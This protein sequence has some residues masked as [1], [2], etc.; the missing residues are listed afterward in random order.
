MGGRAGKCCDRL[1]PMGR[2][3]ELNGP[4]PKRRRDEA[5]TPA[6]LRARELG[7]SSGATTDP[8]F[9]GRKFGSGKSDPSESS[10]TCSA[11]SVVTIPSDDDVDSDNDSGSW[12]P[13]VGAEASSRPTLTRASSS[14][15]PAV[16]A[17]LKPSSEITRS[18]MGVHNF[19]VQRCI[20]KGSFGS[21]Y[22]VKRNGDHEGKLLAMKVLKKGD[23][24]PSNISQIVTE[25]RVLRRAKHPFISQLK[26]AFQ[27]QSRL[28]LVT[29]YLGGGELLAQIRKAGHFSESKAR[30]FLVEIALGLEYLHFRGILHRDLKPE[31]VL[32]DEEGH[33]HLTDFGLSKIG[34]YG[35]ETT[36]TMCGTPEYMPPEIFRNESHGSEQDWW[37]FGV[38]TFELLEGRPAFQNPNRTRLMR[39]IISGKFAFQYSHSEQ[40]SSLI[41]KMLCPDLSARLYGA[42]NVQVHSWF[43]SVDWVHALSLGLKPPVRPGSRA[44]I[45]SNNVEFSACDGE[46]ETVHFQGFSFDSEAPSRSGLFQSNLLSNSALFGSVATT[47]LGENDCSDEEEEHCLTVEDSKQTA[48]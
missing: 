29:E 15:T 16:F 47:V 30:F 38:L 36:T 24:S 10:R 13:D 25:R 1:N 35:D 18:G 12:D 23:A 37:A 4:V 27:S 19:Q 17:V 31:N 26:F 3:E 8:R 41:H 20:G 7:Q 44:P 40:A 2:R 6:A 14:G 5:L 42:A 43:A 22:L 9:F 39:L 21:V 34:V 48:F 33:V 28:Y 46:E 45:S 32:L 11:I